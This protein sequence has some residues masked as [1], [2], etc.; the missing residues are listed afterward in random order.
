[1]NTD[2]VPPAILSAKAPPKKTVANVVLLAITFA[3]GACT[4]MLFV[5][6]SEDD[7]AIFRFATLVIAYAFGVIASLR[8]VRSGKPG[9]AVVGV[10]SLALQSL[11]MLATFMM[12]VGRDDGEHG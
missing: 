2:T 11:V 9:L 7:P 5:N 10:F 4:F 1:M 3:V 6:S 12:L 8:L